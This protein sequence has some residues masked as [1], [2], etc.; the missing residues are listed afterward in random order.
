[1]GGA[2]ANRVEA[3]PEKAKFDVLEA[4]MPAYHVVLTRRGV[5]PEQALSCTSSATTRGCLSL[6]TNQSA[7]PF[8]PSYASLYSMNEMG[9]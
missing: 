3:G 5:Q 6:C 9:S 8:F 2:S 1:M 7:E 4:A